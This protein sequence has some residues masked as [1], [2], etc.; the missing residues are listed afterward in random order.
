MH[1]QLASRVGVGRY[2]QS[3]YLLQKKGPAYTSHLLSFQSGPRSASF[4]MTCLRP[5]PFPRHTHR[6]FAFPCPNSHG[7]R[8]QP[9]ISLTR[10]DVT[11]SITPSCAQHSLQPPFL[12]KTIPRTQTLQIRAKT[13]FAKACE[14]CKG[15]AEECE[16]APCIRQ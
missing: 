14:A 10:I 8:R 11:L 15:W 2:Q 9:P 12:A 16:V 3:H 6:R 13:S 7:Q 4:T 1:H 5:E